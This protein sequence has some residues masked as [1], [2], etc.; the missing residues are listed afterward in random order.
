MQSRKPNQ[1]SFLSFVL[2]HSCC[3][4][5]LMALCMLYMTVRYRLLYVDRFII[6]FLFCVAPPSV[7]DMYVWLCLWHRKRYANDFIRV[8]IMKQHMYSFL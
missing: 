6:V 1:E 8:F 7:P 5:I 2:F 3:N 4:A